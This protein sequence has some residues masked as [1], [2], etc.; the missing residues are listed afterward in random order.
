MR[1]VACEVFWVL[2]TVVAAASGFVVV[3]RH[4]KR[5]ASTLLLRPDNVN[6]DLDLDW[7]DFER[8]LERRPRKVKKAPL[9][10]A[11]PGG[12]L[13]RLEVLNRAVIAGIF[14]AG[15]GAGV[16]IDSAI[17]TNPKDLASRDAIDRNAP[18][19]K[20]CQAY[21]SSAVVLDERVFIT[22]NPFNVY[23][24]QADTKPGC[25]L[26]PSNVVAQLQKERK[27]IT[28][29]DVEACKNGY[30]TWAFVGDIDDRPQLNCVF[31]SDDAQ[32]EFL[33]NPKVG[34]GEDVYDREMS[35]E[36]QKQVIQQVARLGP[37]KYKGP[38]SDKTP[39]A[40]APPKTP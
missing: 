5:S 11:G 19:P 38:G 16:T 30:N 37:V 39:R 2:L 31:Q 33:S 40:P 36:T 18:N 23:V 14:V 21:G 9:V 25:V 27:L 10:S 3:P 32:N 28:N 24:T 34:I 26:R 20:L 17:N 13:P 22:F 35:P 8:G 6:E 12:P 7:E 29:D 1:K 4:N 15:I